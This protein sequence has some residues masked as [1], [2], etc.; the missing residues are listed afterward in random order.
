LVISDSTLF[1]S[2]TSVRLTGV[3]SRTGMRK[4]FTIPMKWPTG[5]AVSCQPR[6]GG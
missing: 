2:H 5:A 1:G 4:A 3:P 6:S